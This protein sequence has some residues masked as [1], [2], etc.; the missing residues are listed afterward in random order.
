MEQGRSTV[1]FT[2]YRTSRPVDP[3]PERPEGNLR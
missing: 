1:E 3:M 2:V